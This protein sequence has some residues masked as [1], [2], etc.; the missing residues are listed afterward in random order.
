MVILVEEVASARTGED[1]E[2]DP[3]L[4]AGGVGGEAYFMGWGTDCSMA[5]IMVVR[6]QKQT[7]DRREIYVAMPGRGVC[8]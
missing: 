3:V 6:W 1:F 4:E 8:V 5:C 2:G 7:D